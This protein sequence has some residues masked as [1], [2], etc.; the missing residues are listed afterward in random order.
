MQKNFKTINQIDINNTETYLDDIFLTFDIDWAPS[1]VVFDVIN[2]LESHNAT[3]TFFC[4]NE[5]ESLKHIE[6]NMELGLHPNFNYLIN[7][8]SRYG[9]THSDV[10]DYYYKF[11]PNAKSFRSHS[12]VNGSPF[13]YSAIEKGLKFDCNHFIP[14]LKSNLHPWKGWEQ[15]M[16][17]I[18]YI[19]EDDFNFL[20]NI[21]WDPKKI[22]NYEGIKVL[23]FHPMHVYLNTDIEETYLKAKPHYHNFKELKKYIN[24]KNYGCRDFLKDIL[25]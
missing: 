23:D 22:L 21:C 9:K 4:T 18:P 15:D 7:G 1:E 10:F 25:S 2:L 16:T 20:Y 3:G 11:A 19:W 24:T 13:R 8:D 17:H 6:K 12:L 14:N 5:C